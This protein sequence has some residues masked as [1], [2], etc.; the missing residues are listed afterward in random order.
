MNQV[1]CSIIC[2]KHIFLYFCVSELEHFDTLSCQIHLCPEH[3]WTGLYQPNR[4]G[5]LSGLALLP[6][7]AV[8][9]PGGAGGHYLSQSPTIGMHKTDFMLLTQEM[10]LI[11]SSLQW[12]I[13][14]SFINND[15]LKKNEFELLEVADSWGYCCGFTYLTAALVHYANT[16]IVCLC[17]RN[18]WSALGVGGGQ[19][20][21]EFSWTI[22][23]SCTLSMRGGSLRRPLSEC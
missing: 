16:V 19:R 21:K 14:D 6:S 9:T 8:W 4:V 12:C 10:P 13:N 22:W 1:V 2:N 18:V 17:L 20:R 3:V 23:I 7:G 15:L 5:R 11:Y